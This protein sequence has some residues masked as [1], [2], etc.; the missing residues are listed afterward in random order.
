MPG[1]RRSDSISGFP[2]VV[3]ASAVGLGCTARDQRE[4]AASPEDSEVVA[5]DFGGAWDLAVGADAVY[6]YWGD[7]NI[8]R[9]PVPD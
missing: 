8:N 7:A 4:C 9:T 3:L 6:L 2:A 5:C 1:F